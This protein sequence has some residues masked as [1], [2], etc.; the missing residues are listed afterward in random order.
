MQNRKV[1]AILDGARDECIVPML[2]QSKLPY[3]C[4]Y[5]EPLSQELRHVAPHLVEL[6]HK[7]GFT[8]ELLEQGWGK[9][10]GFFVATYPP[11]TRINVR[12]NFRK[13]TFVRDPKGKKVYFR[14]YD[15]RVLRVFLPTCQLE[16]VQ[17]IFGPIAEMLIEGEKTNTLHRFQH[18]PQGSRAH[19]LK[20]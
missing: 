15:P 17:T 1:F 12:H 14:Y 13:M 6:S 4:L 3:D 18:S 10:W 8:R 19:L 9:S 2:Q 5:N 11:I 16:Q 7:A 20:I